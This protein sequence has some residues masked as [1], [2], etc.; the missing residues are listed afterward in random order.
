MIHLLLHGLLCENPPPCDKAF[1]AQISSDLNLC[2]DGSGDVSR[3]RNGLSGLS[4]RTVAQCVEVLT[5]WNLVAGARGPGIAQR[6]KHWLWSEFDFR[7]W[8]HMWLSLLLVLF[9]CSESFCLGCAPP[10]LPAKC[11]TSNSNANCKHRSNSHAE[12]DRRFISSPIL[13]V[14]SLG[15]V[16]GTPW[17]ICILMNIASVGFLARGPARTP[18]S[19][20]RHAWFT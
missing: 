19:I 2:H 17:T 14:I 4:Y 12:S 9:H 11:T 15:N 5:Q 18:Y 13:H 3:A 16:P 20:W 7:N 1:V 8:C 10:L 6:C